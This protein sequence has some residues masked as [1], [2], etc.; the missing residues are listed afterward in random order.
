[1]G[2]CNWENEPDPSL[3][4]LPGKDLFLVNNSFGG[5]TKG[6]ALGRGTP[7]DNN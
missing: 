7:L 4:K 5:E 3:A 1:M 6:A 2:W